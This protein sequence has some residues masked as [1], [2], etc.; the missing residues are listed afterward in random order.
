MTANRHDSTAG[1]KRKP[2]GLR[3][4]GCVGGAALVVAAAI[5]LWLTTVT[6]P[7]LFAIP[8]IL[9]VVFFWVLELRVVHYEFQREAHA[10]SLS[11]LALVVGFFSVPAAALPVV[12]VIGTAAALALSRGQRGVKLFYN[13]GHVWLGT[14]LSVAVF[15]LLATP[16]SASPRTWMAGLVAVTVGQLVNML[17]ITFAIWRTEGINGIA[18]FARM[19]M[20]SVL[21]SVTTGNVALIGV[22]VMA[23]EPLGIVLFVGPV[24]VMFVAFRAY[25]SERTKRDSLEFLHESSQILHSNPDI[26]EAIYQLLGRAREAFK[27]DTAEIVLLPEAGNGALLHTKVDHSNKCAPGLVD[28]EWHDVHGVFR[29]SLEKGGPMLIRSNSIHS[30]SLQPYLADRGYSEAMLVPL[31]GETRVIGGLMLTDRLSSVSRFSESDLRLFTTLANQTSVALENG[32]LEKTLV[33]VSKLKDELHYQAYHD[34]LTGLANRALFEEEIEAAVRSANDEGNGRVGVLYVDLDDF[35]L[36]NDTLGHDAGDAVLI[37]V[38]RRLRDH[39]RSGDTAARLGGDEF[40]VILRNITDEEEAVDI[41]QRLVNSARERVNLGDDLPAIRFSVGIAVSRPQETAEEL[42]RH[43]DQAMYQSKHEG[44]HHLQLYQ[45]GMSR[46]GL[47]QSHDVAT[48]HSGVAERYDK[49]HSA[50]P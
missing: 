26:D 50:D 22:T 20:S 46:I 11:E 38:A 3:A 49:P 32:R 19:S 12:G 36:I 43:A 37:E 2:D 8:A 9:F 29:R 23:N 28:M 5:N 47:D 35:K 13:A 24:A 16:D 10:H 27:A 4:V 44:K 14:T 42:I 25:I 30:P 41:A 7:T 21:A 1:G 15:H 17:A 34:A 45:S 33:Q 18:K 31:K 6:S 39:C 48:S 40:A